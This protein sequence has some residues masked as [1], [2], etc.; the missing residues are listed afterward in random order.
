LKIMEAYADVRIDTNDY[1]IHMYNKDAFSPLSGV[2][3]EVG[4][5]TA[6]RFHR[7]RLTGDELLVKSQLGWTRGGSSGRREAY[8]SLGAENNADEVSRLA[9]AALAVSSDPPEEVALAYVARDDSEIPYVN[10][11]LVPGCTATVPTRAGG[12]SLERVVRI[13]CSWADDERLNVGVSVKS[14]VLQTQERILRQI[15]ALA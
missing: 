2:E 12:T 15:K 13:E 5:L 1:L 14:L 3:F 11:L 6:L 10:S 4:N 7:T 9:T 8:L